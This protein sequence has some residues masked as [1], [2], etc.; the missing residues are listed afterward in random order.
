M[1][2]EIESVETS[3]AEQECIICL[4]PP[5]QHGALRCVSGHLLCS[6]CVDAYTASFSCELQSA[7][8]ESLDGPKREG[9]LC[10]PS[11]PKLAFTDAEVAQHVSSSTFESYLKG[12]SL[13]AIHEAKMETFEE[14]Q[15]AL[16]A[17]LA[18]LPTGVAAGKRQQAGGALLAKQ[19]RSLLK[20]ARQCKECKWGPLDFRDC[21]NLSAHHDQVIAKA[22]IETALEAGGE[23]REVQVKIDNSCPRCGWFSS[24]LQGWPKWDGNLHYDALPSRFEA[25]ELVERKVKVATAKL[26]V[27]EEAARKAEADA[28]TVVEARV[29]SEVEALEARTEAA[30][31][32]VAT[33]KREAAERVAA[34]EAKAAAEVKRREA[35][36]AS[37]ERVRAGVAATERACLEATRRV[38]ELHAR[39]EALRKKAEAA[40]AARRAATGGEGEQ[41]TTRPALKQLYAT[42]PTTAPPTPRRADGSSLRQAL[43]NARMEC[44]A[45]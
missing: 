37:E 43:E 38:R 9:R 21:D 8:L 5:S 30:E 33:A 27:A 35:A 12:R 11:C 1:T 17:E 29:K 36:E 20:D 2:A 31:A 44:E 19:L 39:E 23:A 4:Q 13:W 18:R 42:G 40:L 28:L 24:N 16:S 22:N 14:A 6:P 26:A 7:D 32:T 41:Q 34:A 15:A 3:P 45:C 25:A 10:C